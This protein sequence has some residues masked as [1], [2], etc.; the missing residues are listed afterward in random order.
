MLYGKRATRPDGHARERKAAHTTD[1][2][3]EDTQAAGTPRWVKVL[4]AIALVV[5]VLVVI[6]V[7]TGRGGPH[8]P[9]RHAAPAAATP[10][11]SAAH[12]APSG[13]HTQR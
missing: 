4:G 8:S 3:D 10:S 13:A 5:A 12:N 9:R 6:L 11:G 2:R 7:L 1:M